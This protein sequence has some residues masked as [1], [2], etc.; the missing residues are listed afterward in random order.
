ML[1][2]SMEYTSELPI[3][4]IVNK[5]VMAYA[6]TCIQKRMIAREIH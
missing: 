4:Y 5:K 2:N 6:L 3:G 1:F